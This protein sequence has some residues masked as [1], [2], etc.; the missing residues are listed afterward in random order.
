MFDWLVLCAAIAAIGDL[1]V[2]I[3]GWILR[4]PWP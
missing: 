1:P 4:R 3:T 2:R